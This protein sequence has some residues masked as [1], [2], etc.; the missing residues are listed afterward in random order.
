MLY[1]TM[2]GE[3]NMATL[4]HHGKAE[5]E[6]LEALSDV[7]RRQPVGRSVGSC[8]NVTD[9]ERFAA[10]KYGAAQNQLDELTDHLAV[11]DRCIDFL[12]QS[13][14]RR[15]LR[16]TTALVLAS[17]VV[18]VIAL[19]ASLQHTSRVVVGVATVDLRL[20]S[21]T[22]GQ[23]PGPQTA[24]VR[25]ATDRLRIVLPVGSEGNYEMAILA[26]DAKP[27]PLLHSSGNAKLEGHDVVL[28]LP[29]NLTH[30]KSAKY[31]LTLRRDGYEWEY[32]SLTLE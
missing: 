31:L 7:V 9:L 28:D 27:T 17:A 22:R 2:N 20:L 10:G 13:R 11:C 5:Q 18:L 3:E 16:R 8:P 6:L 4:R 29:P 32:Y 12:T 19:W 1:G 23:V 14:K 26:V 15:E 30:L 21:P 24:T 25:K